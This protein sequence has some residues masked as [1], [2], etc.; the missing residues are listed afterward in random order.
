MYCKKKKSLKEY[1]RNQI[2][3]NILWKLRYINDYAINKINTLINK[4]YFS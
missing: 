3:P 4:E 2:A 1:Y